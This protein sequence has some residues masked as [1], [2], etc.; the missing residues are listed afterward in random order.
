MSNFTTYELCNFDS[1][2]ISDVLVKVEKSFGFKFTVTELKDVKTFG[3]LS[4]L[5][6][7]KIQGVNSNDCTTQQAFYKLRNAIAGALQIERKL[8]TPDTNMIKLFPRQNRRQYVKEISIRI[9][10]EFEILEIK[11]WLKWVCFLGILFSLVV[12]FFKMW[13]G[14]IGLAF[15]SF[16]TL[17]LNKYFATEIALQTVGQCAE[18]FSR[19]NYFKARRNMKTVNKLEIEKT[20][21]DL[22]KSELGLEDKNLTREKTF[23]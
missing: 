23:V 5:I 1:D 15:F 12:F 13:F 6:M 17:I 3:E 10:A 22:F 14:L 20:V 9:N 19:E 21:Q 11:E 16:L 2:D 18:K 4:D 8:I 7:N